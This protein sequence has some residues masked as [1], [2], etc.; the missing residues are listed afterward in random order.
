MPSNDELKDRIIEELRRYNLELEKTLKEKEIEITLLK[1]KLTE[2]SKNLESVKDKDNKKE[3]EKSETKK[4]FFG[5]LSK[6]KK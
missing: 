4:K 6:R 1:E 2:L 5:F 3:A